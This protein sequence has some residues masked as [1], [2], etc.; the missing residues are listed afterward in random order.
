MCDDLH[1]EEERIHKIIDSLL[2]AQL[3]ERKCG[4]IDIS[5]SWLFVILDYQASRDNGLVTSW[6]DYYTPEKV[7]QAENLKMVTRMSQR[8]VK[9]RILPTFLRQ[10]PS[11]KP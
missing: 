10:I 2:N 7:N 11:G 9:N 1:I 8:I 3:L 4:D 5:D 6:S